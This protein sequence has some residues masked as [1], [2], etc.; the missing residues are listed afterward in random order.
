[1]VLVAA[2][3]WGADHTLVFMGESGSS[4][5]RGAQ[6]G[7]DE[8]N[9]QGRFLGAEFSLAGETTENAVA[10]VAEA[11]HVAKALTASDAAVLNVTNRANEIRGHCQANLLHTIP[12]VAMLQSARE[13]WRKTHPDDEAVT[14]H[15][16]HS[17]AYKFAARDLNKRFRE[18]FGAAMDDDAWA[19]WAAVRMVAD[20]VFRTQSGEATAVLRYLREEMEFDGNKGP[21]H[22]FR[23]TG[24]LRQP[25]MIAVENELAGEAPVRGAADPNDLDSL[26]LLACKNQ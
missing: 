13:Q 17:A 3:L 14:A 21:A 9:L 11:E 1:M 10:I 26:G 18:K 7:L 23:A 8:A 16:W 20:A 22:S 2:P 25:L 15:A 6:L 4:A 24:Q 12:S 5:W 19:A